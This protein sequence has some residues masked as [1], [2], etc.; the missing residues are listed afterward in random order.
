MTAGKRQS[1]LWLD[2]SFGEA[3]GRFA[4]TD[5]REVTESE[6]RSKERKPPGAGPPCGLEEP[7]K[8]EPN[9]RCRRKRPPDA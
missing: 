3:L 8:R 2:M 4:G 6:E 1:L 9:E 7:Q 5:P